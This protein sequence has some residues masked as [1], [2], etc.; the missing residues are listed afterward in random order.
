[1]PTEANVKTAGL[2]VLFTNGDDTHKPKKQT[3]PATWIAKRKLVSSLVAHV[4]PSLLGRAPGSHVVPL[5]GLIADMWF[6][7]WFY[8]GLAASSVLFSHV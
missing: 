4:A 2:T 6:C 3:I 5:E 7:Q 8:K 1:M